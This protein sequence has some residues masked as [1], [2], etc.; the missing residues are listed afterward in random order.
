M[1]NILITSGGTREYIDDVRVMTNI[2]SGKLGKIIAMKMVDLLHEKIIFKEA[3]VHFIYEKHTECPEYE[4]ERPE[5]GQIQTYPIQS[6]QEAYDKMQEL[7]PKMDAV[8][9]CMAVSDFTFKRDVALKCKSS[10][11]EAFIEYMRRTITPNP[12][13][14]SCI[15]KWNPKVILVGFKF[16]V[17]ASLSDLESL[18]KASIQKNGCDMVIANDKEEMKRRSQHVGHFFFSDGM[19]TKGFQDFEQIGKSSIAEALCGCIMRII[20]VQG[21]L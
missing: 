17:G 13:I 3:S 19:K 10:D 12:K 18:A 16:E 2:S 6:A 7:V 8:I 4:L 21:S 14:I 5:Y 15:K 1:Y 9:H 20:P 11:P